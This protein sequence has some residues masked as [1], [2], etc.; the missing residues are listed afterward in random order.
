MYSTA[1][2]L[3]FFL[4]ISITEY[5]F[6]FST[7]YRKIM[8]YGFIT[9][10]LLSLVCLVGI[11]LLKIRKLGK[12]ISHQQAANIIGNHF[13]RVKDTLVNVLQLKASEISLEQAA[14]VEASINQKSLALKSVPFT[15]AIDL[16]ENRY[17]LKYALPPLLVFLALLFFKPNVIKESSQRLI[18]NGVVF[19]KPMP[20]K[21]EISEESLK[22]LQFE[23]FRLSIK[24]SGKE[25]PNEIFLYRKTANLEFTKTTPQKLNATNFSY[26]FSNLQKDVK[27]YFEANGFR[28]KEYILEISE[29]PMITKFQIKLNYPK[30]LRKKN[31]VLKNT[32]DI[33]APFGTSVDWLFEA[34]ATEKINIRF[35]DALIV[36]EKE[37]LKEFNYRKT[38]IIN[39]LYTVKTV[40]SSV[41]KTDS[42]QFNINVVRDEYP[43]ISVKEHQDSTNLDIYYYTGEISDDYGLRKLTFNY[44]IKNENN[45][46]KFISKDIPFQKNTLSGFTYF[47]NI[48]ELDLS[49][50]DNLT[51]YF[52]VWDNDGVNG[53]KFST[54]KWMIL[55][56][57]SL[58]EFENN[59]EQEL[60]E[61]T[62]DLKEAI[63][64]SQELQ[65]EMKNF[66]N[67]LL[68]KKE[69]S[70][71][72][73]N[74]MK[75]LLNE[76]KN[77]QNKISKMNEKLKENIQN[78][79]KFKEINPE[80]A[81]KQEKIQKLFDEVLDAK[82]KKLLEKY[83]K[84]IKELT[85]EKTLEQ[86]EEIKITDEALEKELDRML[87]LLKKLAFDQKLQETQEKL[88][89]LA[90][91]QEA[92]AN[93]KTK[94][95]EEL[96]KEQEK[97]NEEFDKLTE[98]LKDLE[99]LDEELGDKIDMEELLEE[100]EETSEEMDNAQENLL[101]GK[102]KKASESQKSA[103]QK[104]NEMAKKLAE[105]TMSMEAESMGENMQSLR[106]LLENLV[107]LSYEEE[108]LL[109]EF[110][111]TRINT[112]KYVALVQDQ[113]KVS[114]TSEL[115][116]DSLFALAKR[117]LE[118]ESF[119]TDKIF[120]IN[121]NLAA[122]I[123]QLEERI[124]PKAVVNQQ[125]VM[126]GYNDLALM[127]SEVL[128]Q[129]QQQMAMQMEGNQSCEKPG[130]GK[131]KSGKIPS[132]KKMQQQL[133]DQIQKMGE[134]TKPGKDREKSGGKSGQS[135]EFAKMAAKQQ[136]I[137]EA[138]Q[139][140]KDAGKKDDRGK[141]NLGDLQKI[142]DEMKKNESDLVN[143][144][145]SN[146]LLNR[147]KEIMTRLLEAENSE[148][149]R[150]EKEERKSE[151]G[152]DF[153]NKT[154]P[155]LIEY[156]K[157]R[158]TYLDLYKQTSPNLKPYYRNISEKY[159]YNSIN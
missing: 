139:K 136:A 141:N 36:L 77:L 43:Q 80:I 32:G 127:L 99:K 6:Y 10:S 129:M 69:M 5:N 85:K 115:V 44:K 51:Y 20:F 82:M 34:N 90:E 97:L 23:D 9:F 71:E 124:V 138:I 24:I 31:I 65:K 156:L 133:S 131:P 106:Q 87:E 59:S 13:T 27:F 25:I 159:F 19:E 144:R 152:A 140:I 135:K 88:E 119:I 151:Q 4:I 75:K 102:K 8:F 120:E 128:Q 40:S 123:K 78:Q 16:N 116:E 118:I 113:H 143:K 158:K 52:K 47:W 38:L 55:K 3:V 122:S 110:K 114:Q 109:N 89:K 35:S 28:S 42:V 15:S 105:M 29:K 67:K 93:N 53:S 103:A 14:L 37:K 26:I 63:E 81:K 101:K 76:Q 96:Q 56:I 95:T 45:D 72:D 148:R 145:L 66:K 58:E 112:P 150:D 107:Y 108:R 154:P 18:Q 46:G 111:V 126:T 94:Q 64:K 30:Y 57:P 17:Y 41:L 74:K 39:E 83:E 155:A 12:I 1:I 104:M 100:G 137:R 130:N 146:N 61:L 50:G 117:V 33:S 62:K 22:S 79:S 49:A 68:N 11:P 70:W 134:K 121:R 125:Y 2:L 147:Q 21:F 157:K 7:F 54:S 98:E 132:L 86:T 153:I 149:Q 92:L 48:T 60:A 73:K 142:I 91:K 84:M